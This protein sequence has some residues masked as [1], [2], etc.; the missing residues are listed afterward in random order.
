[1]KAKDFQEAAAERIVEL[2]KAGQHRVLLADEVGLGKTI[3]AKT[4][5]EK[6]GLWRRECKAEDYVVV[7]ICSNAGIADQNCS[8]L[9]IAK[10]N[11]VSISEGRLSMQHLKLAELSQKGA[12]RLIPMTPATSFQMRGG[13]GTVRERAL[14]YL[15]MDDSHLFGSYGEEMSLLM[16]TFFIAKDG[17]WQQYVGE[18]NERIMQLADEKRYRKE[19]Q[20]CLKE[21]LSPELIN[22]IKAVCRK[23]RRY[24]V[25]RLKENARLDAVISWREQKDLINRIRYCFAEISL[26]MLNPNLV[27]MDEFQRF[28]DLIEVDDDDKSDSAMLSRKFLREHTDSC[29]LLLSATPYK[30]YSTLTELTEGEETH[31]EGFFRVMNFLANGEEE[32]R[33]FHTVWESYSGHLS[34]LRGH[35]LSVLLASKQAAQD[36]LYRYMCRTERRSAGILNTEKA[37]PMA[38]QQ[39]GSGNINSYIEIQNITKALGLGNF[40]VE[41]VKSAPFL[42]SF[43]NYR[44]KD[45]IDD[46][47]HGKK[48]VIAPEE[49]AQLI[50]RMPTAFLKR[51]MINGYQPLPD[52]NARL[53]AL[54]DEVFEAEKGA[55]ELLL[56][57]PPSNPYYDTGA[58][59]MFKQC[60]GYSKTL[61]FSSWE[62]V[63]RALAT[64]TSYEAERRVNQRIGQ[65]NAEQRSYYAV[66]EEDQL[67]DEEQPKNKRN[68]TRFLTGDQRELVAYPSVWLAGKYDGRKYYGVPLAKLRRSVKS[69][70]RADIR[71]EMRKMRVWRP[72]SEGR[73]SAKQLLALLKYMDS[74][75]PEVGDAADENAEIP[76]Q[77]PSEGDLD[78]LVLMAIGSPAVCLFRALPGIASVSERME[79]AREC[80]DKNFVSMFNRPE[81]RSI[82]DAVYE[83][84]RKSGAGFDR[85]YERVF[86]YCV[87]GNFQSMID[88]YKFALGVDD[89]AFPEA[90]RDSFLQTSNL[91]YVSQE[92]YRAGKQGKQPKLRVHFAAGY[93]DA[94]ISE[95]AVLHVS[96]VRNAFNSPFRPFVLATTSIGQEGLDFHLYSRKVMHWNLPYNP[97][98]LEQREGRINRY[99]CHAIRQNV[100]VNEAGYD[101]KEMF[102]RTREKYGKQHSELVPYWCLPDEYPYR[103]QIERI[104]PMYPFSQDKSRYDRLINVLAL[105]RLTLGQP[106]QEELIAILQREDLSAEQM[107][108]LF[109]DLSPYSRVKKERD[110]Q[111]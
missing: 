13:A 64:L 69:E 65:K 14:A 21:R 93:F 22:E 5:V 34:E 2:F 27:I 90:I 43:M 48:H 15:L 80:C 70:I 42:M 86:S 85:H 12:V 50:R 110:A 109:F 23:L 89:E 29:V 95:K 36:E 67:V 76:E 59:S 77:F 54:F 111:A 78:A 97:I 39:L 4:V 8:K 45:K 73:L 75:M 35:D 82:M 1:M 91:P 102:A 74:R 103:Y 10:E 58:G 18:Q 107:E 30:P 61:V 99:L 33:R 32:K 47:L 26:G 28:R 87:D 96:R 16:R 37:R 3:V 57:I 17:S 104:V 94:R 38:M 31:Q 55:P 7:Y 100:A 71:A 105:Y 53:H 98:N 101:W 106:R 20:A 66:P 11:R 9:G 44:I 79:A 49:S 62:M 51:S 40:P 83:K 68:K 41:Y 72:A 19:M 24:G 52:T 6:T 88:E 92:Y 81:S 46:A 25:E 84:D 60:E 108:E 56:W 63:P